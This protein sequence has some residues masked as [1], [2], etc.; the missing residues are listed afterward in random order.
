VTMLIT[1]L[2]NPRREKLLKSCQ[3]AGREH[4][5]AE[6]VFLELLQVPLQLVRQ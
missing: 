4:L 2:G 6:R 3:R 5:G 1:V